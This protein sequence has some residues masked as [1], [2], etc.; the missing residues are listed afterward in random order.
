MEGK[1]SR[2][3]DPQLMRDYMQRLSARPHNVGRHTTRQRAMAGA[4]FKEF[5]L[6]THI[7]TFLH[8]VPHAERA[9]RELIEG[10][11]NCR[12][13]EELRLR[14]SNFQPSKR[15]APTYNAYSIDATYSAAGPVNYGIPEDYSN[16]RHGRSVKGAI[17]ISKY[18][19]R[20]RH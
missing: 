6:D 7:E 17:V 20:G 19:I 15:A 14:G 16:W 9:G 3:F 13:V 1:S 5:G 2:R 18:G 4:K 10:G 12:E 8:F 11:P